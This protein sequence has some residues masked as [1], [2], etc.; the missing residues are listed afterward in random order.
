MSLFLDKLVNAIVKVFELFEKYAVLGFFLWQL[1]SAKVKTVC[2]KS[3]KMQTNSA[4]RS[5]RAH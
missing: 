5:C 2:P 4:P 1:H 3:S